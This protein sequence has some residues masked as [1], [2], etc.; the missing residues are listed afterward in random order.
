MFENT[1]EAE[2]FQQTL[3]RSAMLNH[4]WMG[5]Y[6]PAYQAQFDME[7]ANILHGSF[8]DEEFAFLANTVDYAM[9]AEDGAF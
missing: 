7:V 5:V 2:S 4:A 9:L 3:A 6:L 8:T 1:K